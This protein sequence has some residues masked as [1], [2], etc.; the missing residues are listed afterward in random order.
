MLEN[1][2][3]EI[4]NVISFELKNPNVTGLISVTKA[5]ITPDL[6]YAKIYVSILNS[7]N[8]KKTMEGLKES[9]G[10]I[11]TQVAKTINLRI[12]PELIFELDDSLEYGEKIEK[13][14]KSVRCLRCSLSKKKLFCRLIKWLLMKAFGSFGSISYSSYTSQCSRLVQNKNVPQMSFYSNKR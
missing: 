10:F 5:K 11:R 3:K 6:K 4:S 7:K 9:T 1:L 12:T 14:L 2:K 13:I 8:L